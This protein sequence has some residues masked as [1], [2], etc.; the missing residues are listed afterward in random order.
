M[1]KKE[2]VIIP[3]ISE[4][5]EVENLDVVKTKVNE[6]RE[7]FLSVHKNVMKKNRIIS[8]IYF[9]ITIGLVLLGTFVEKLMGLSFGVIC[10]GLIFVWIYTRKQRKEM[11]AGTQGYLRDYSLYTNSYMYG[12]EDVEDVKIAYSQKVEKDLINK[13]NLSNE[14]YIINSRDVVTGKMYS[15][16]FLTCDVSINSGAAKR[17]R[18]Q[19]ILF[20]GKLFSLNYKF[21]SEGRTLLYLKGCGDA[22]PTKLEDVNEVRV[23]SLKKEWQ[24]YTSCKD[25]EKI[26]NSSLIK[27]LNKLECNETLN[28]IVISIADGTV[29]V[30]YSYSDEA[31]VIPMNTTYETKQ[32]EEKVDNYKVFKDINKAL[33]DNNNFIKE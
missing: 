7:K 9:G 5:V 32:F 13:I 2:T 30:G 33:I 27:A 1:E 26:F 22:T 31:M 4:P 8:T 12:K 16:N 17:P 14:E 20:V 21:V 6:A 15:H 25:Y 28:D 10:A 23:T 19:K 11:D 29:L 3:E 18:E 24:V